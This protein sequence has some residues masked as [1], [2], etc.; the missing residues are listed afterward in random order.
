LGRNLLATGSFLQQVKSAGKP[1]KKIPTSSPISQSPDRY[2]YIAVRGPI[3]K[4]GVSF[5][6]CPERLKRYYPALICIYW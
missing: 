6:C 3:A 1:E 5:F 2:Y 4:P